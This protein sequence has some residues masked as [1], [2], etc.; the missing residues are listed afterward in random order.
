MQLLWSALVLPPLLV[1]NSANGARPESSPTGRPLTL[2][3][4]W[5]LDATYSDPAHGVT[6]RYPSTWRATK[7]FA[8]HPPVLENSFAPPIAEFA[9]EEGGFPRDKIV[10]PYS[11]TN[12]E[13]VGILYSAINAASASKCREMAY[14]LSNSP[15]HSSTVSLGGRSFSVFETGE[16][17]MSQSTSISLYVTYSNHTCFLFE[18]DVA[19]ADEDAADL[20]GLTTSQLRYIFAHLE[21]IMKSVR[22]A[23]RR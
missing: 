5:T 9:H 6:F 2:A 14:S 21:S 15:R 7:E 18:T 13:A 3:Q 17:G 1:L 11:S 4:V 23:S 8:Y 10:G 16:A 12:L 20:P 22:I 19:L